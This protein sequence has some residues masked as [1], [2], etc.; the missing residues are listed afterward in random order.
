MQ[1]IVGEIDASK[2]SSV[3]EPDTTPPE[4]YTGGEE[5][6]DYAEFARNTTG[7]CDPPF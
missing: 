3:S 5:H 6:G 1:Q 7:H 2:A 4:V